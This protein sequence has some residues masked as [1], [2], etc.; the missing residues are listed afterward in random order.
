M[1]HVSLRNKKAT[2]LVSSRKANW[3][4]DLLRHLSTDWARSGRSVVADDDSPIDHRDIEDWVAHFIEDNHQTD[5]DERG[6]ILALIYH[7]LNFDIPFAATRN[8]RAELLQIAR[9]NLKSK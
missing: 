2:D 5:G 1:G 7:S 3:N 8:V 4:E 6:L 9:E